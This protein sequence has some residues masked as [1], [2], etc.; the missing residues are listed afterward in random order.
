MF[1]LA[2][3][4]FFLGLMIFAPAWR[5]AGGFQ[6]EGTSGAF[7]ALDGKLALVIWTDKSL[8]QGCGTRAW[9]FE[10][11]THLANG[12][13]LSW[14]CKTLNG[15]SG[16]VTIEGKEYDL[17]KG[18]IFLVGTRGQK[19]VIRQLPIDVSQI[20]V[21]T[22]DLGDVDKV[23]TQLAKDVAAVR[24]FVAGKNLD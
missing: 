17:A 11:Q 21:G 8:G 1:K 23:F 19:P 9:G 22:P 2:Q 15:R 14:A 10:G 6:V 12:K 7:C 5:G 4:S 3:L 20:A 13:D 24:N 16:K 18:G